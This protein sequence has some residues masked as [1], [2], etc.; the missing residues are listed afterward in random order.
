MVKFADVYFDLTELGQ[1][2]HIQHVKSN[3]IQNFLYEVACI[4]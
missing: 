2:H 1:R 3:H 4:K